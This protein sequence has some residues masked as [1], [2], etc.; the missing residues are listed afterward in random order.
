MELKK[1]VKG[2]IHEFSAEIVELAS[3]ASVCNINAD[4]NTGSRPT[5]SSHSKHDSISSD[6]GNAS[7]LSL[8]DPEVK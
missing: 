2:D 5:S 6:A 3:K 1:A 7:D 8:T 4:A